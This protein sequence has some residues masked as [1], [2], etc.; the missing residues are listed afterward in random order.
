MA[1]IAAGLGLLMGLALGRIQRDD[2]GDDTRVSP[3]WLRE[4]VY[5]NG[6]GIL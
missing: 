5:R 2:V 6:K 3:Q 1:F 4:F